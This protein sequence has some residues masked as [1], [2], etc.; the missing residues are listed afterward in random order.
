MTKPSAAAVH[1]QLARIFASPEFRDSLKLQS[2]LRFIVSLALAGSSDQIKESSIALEVFSRETSFDSNSDSIVRSA[3]RRLRARLEQ[4]YAGPG[5]GDAVWINIPK[6]NYVPEICLRAPDEQSVEE[7]TVPQAA[8][9]P[10]PRLA[11]PSH[12]AIAL[13]AGL[14]VLVLIS[15]LVAEPSLRHRDV[16]PYIPRGEAYD[17]YARAQYALA[18][19]GQ[20][21]PLFQEAVD[22]DPSFTAAQIG[23]A[24]A[25]TQKAAND[26]IEPEK[27]LSRAEQAASNAIRLDPNS[28]DAHATLG[29]ID[30]CRWKWSEADRQFRI[31]T[32]LG[33][34]NANSWRLWALVHFARG[35]F[36]EA[37][38]TLKRAATL[39]RGTL[40][41]E[42]MLA[43]IYYYERHYNQAIAAAR[44]LLDV[45]H[46]NYLARWVVVSSLTQLGRS[47]NALEEWRPLL[48]SADYGETAA[49]QWA[50]FR[51]HTGDTADL[52]TYVQSCG[53]EHSSYCS[54]WIIA[55]AYALLGDR[56]NC[57]RYLRESVTRHDPD[58]VSLRW[59]PLFDPVRQEPEYQA[60]IHE[61]G[62]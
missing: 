45:D 42:P 47:E 31:A 13:S 12:V 21:L 34:A 19:H 53:V 56:P 27:S 17:Y 37:E 33:S 46:N 38:D 62:F 9:S 8:P 10:R 49:R 18:H 48:R 30:Y 57:L 15:L 52:K 25:Y 60:I 40:Q 22:M 7:K 35:Q 16:R 44:R 29:Y 50:F 59:E 43:Q 4:Y 5:A 2:F 39:E 28:A 3:A 51:A 11:R 61:L 14:L 54:P 6:G 24:Q 32:R 41:A 26:E 55:Q 23:L 20:A 36:D 58:L 1:D